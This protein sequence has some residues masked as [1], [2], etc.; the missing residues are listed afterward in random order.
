MNNVT[1]SEGLVSP[2]VAGGRGQGL[3]AGCRGEE[4]AGRPEARGTLGGG[5]WREAGVESSWSTVG[6]K[7]PRGY[8][9][10]GLGAWMT[11]H[12]IPFF[13]KRC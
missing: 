9:F 3:G 6:W 1:V 11:C 4:E 10:I 7:I 8:V 5:R 2:A 12:P 13:P